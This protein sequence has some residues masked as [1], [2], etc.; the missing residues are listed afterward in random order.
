M[1]SKNILRVYVTNE[2]VK[3]FF[4]CY[5]FA[6]DTYIQIGILYNTTTTCDGNKSSFFLEY[7]YEQK[8][9]IKICAR[10]CINAMCFL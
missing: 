6:S 1:N 9:Q 5:C 2:S 8:I 10:N 7:N 4:T 3:L